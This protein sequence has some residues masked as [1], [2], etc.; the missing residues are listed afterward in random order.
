MKPRLPT[1]PLFLESA[2][3]Y[4]CNYF[5][6]KTPYTCMTDQ[7]R[8]DTGSFRGQNSMPKK[9]AGEMAFNHT[10]ELLKLKYEVGCWML[11]CAYD[12]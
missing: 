5:V 11:T 8:S 12:R 10:T 3:R 2:N 6:Y 7:E 1:I 4:V 9:Q